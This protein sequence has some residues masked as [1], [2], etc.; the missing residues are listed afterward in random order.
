MKSVLFVVFSFL[1]FSKKTALLKPKLSRTFFD[2]IEKRDKKRLEERA[3]IIIII[4]III[5][6]TSSSLLFE[7]EKERERK[8]ERV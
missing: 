2:S 7:R 5:I 6:I 4:I 1:L 3:L 8:K